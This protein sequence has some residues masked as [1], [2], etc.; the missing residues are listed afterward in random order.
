MGAQ[1]FLAP[2]PVFVAFPV[3]QQTMASTTEGQ[4]DLKK[5]PSGYW[6]W[7]G[8][9]RADIVKSLGGSKKGSE[10][11]KK[12]G[13]MW[14]ALSPDEQVPYIEKSKRMKEEIES[15]KPPKEEKKE[16]EIMGKR[17]KPMTAVFAFI[18]EKRSEIA[19]MPGV[20]GLGQISKKGAEL[21]L[22]LPA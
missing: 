1:G 21:F 11:S 22:A 10:V 16:K 18:Q 17:K 13:E 5:A 19:S 7:L 6:L 12:A 15:K 3:D 14:K 9:H 8:E 2:G 4:K 20:T